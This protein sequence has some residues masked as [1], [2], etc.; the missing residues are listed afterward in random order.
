MVI[1]LLL[2]KWLAD[3]QIRGYFY[4]L[5]LN[6]RFIEGARERGGGGRSS[7]EISSRMSR[8]HEETM[9]GG[10]EGE[11]GGGSDM[12]APARM[13]LTR[14]GIRFGTPGR[15]WAQSHCKESVSEKSEGFTIR[16]LNRLNSYPAPASRLLEMQSDSQV[17][18]T[19]RRSRNTRRIQPDGK[20]IPAWCQP[21]SGA[22]L[23]R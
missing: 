3:Y 14:T 23:C 4:L 13:T 6:S 2:I 9:R 10:R 11:A 22:G 8:V 15:I 19:H 12:I 16:H 18:G 1:L 7:D 20:C 17:A 21:V 5:F